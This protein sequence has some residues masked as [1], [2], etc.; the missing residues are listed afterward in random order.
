[1]FTRERDVRVARR[2]VSSGRGCGERGASLVLALMF[3]SCVGVLGAS[4]LALTSVSFKTTQVVRSASRKLYAADG[5]ADIAIQSLRADTSYCGQVSGTPQAMPSETIKGQ[6]VSLACQTLS[7]TAGGGSSPGGATYSVVVTGYPNPDGSSANLSTLISTST[8]QDGDIVNLGGDVFNAGGFS[9]PSSGFN[10]A[11]LH[12]LHE[13]NASSPY[14]T[15][16]K[17]ASRQPIVS[18][19]W[20]CDAGTAGT[21]PVAPDPQP[22]LKVTATSAP[23]SWTSGSGSSQCKV[24][25][26]GR[27][28]SAPSFSSGQN[29]LA[30]GAYYFNN[31]GNVTL[32][33]TV[34]GGAPG[35]NTQVLAGAPCSNDAAAKAHLAGVNDMI[36]GSGVQLVVDG[37]SRLTINGTSNDNME[38]FLR[39][40]GDPASEGTAGVGLL[41]PRIA[42]TGYQKWNAGASPA[43]T[44]AGGSNAANNVVFHGLVYEP[45]SGLSAPVLQNPGGTA[46]FSGGIVSQS[47]FVQPGSSFTG[48][49]TPAIASLP[50]PAP[51]TP[52]TTVVSATATGVDGSVPT[53]VKVVVQIGTSAATP[54]TI[55]SWRKL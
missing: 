1:M 4:V 36:G 52:R 19:S 41:A 20:T 50:V 30:S 39:V 26:P 18:G 21:F 17:S 37:T 24:F 38:F 22:T 23:A 2:A 48:G 43:L 46:M 28:T 45:T 5:G 40:P 12:D 29:Y 34:F 51:A 6:T 44:F 8:G 35:S 13:L 42:G 16:A 47:M 9:F 33:G 14:C 27:Y 55:I 11:V 53:T 31:V 32:Q 7:G 15:S 54:P 3:V 49:S 25:F 10:L